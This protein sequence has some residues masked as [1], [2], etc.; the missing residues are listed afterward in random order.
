M[1]LALWEYGEK[2]VKATPN[3]ASY[4]EHAIYFMITF[5]NQIMLQHITSFGNNIFVMRGKPHLSFDC[6]F[7]LYFIVHWTQNI[8]NLSFSISKI[9]FKT[10]F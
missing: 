3:L 7:F 5:L 1:Y 4:R 10:A 6:H 2:C 8:P 9:N